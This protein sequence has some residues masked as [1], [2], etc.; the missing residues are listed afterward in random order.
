MSSVLKRGWVAT[1]L[2]GLVAG[3]TAAAPATAASPGIQAMPSPLRFVSHLDLECFKTNPYQ[4]PQT[5]IFTRHLNPVLAHLPNETHVLGPREQLCVPVAKNN[6]LPPAGVLEFVRFV[7]LSCY[8]IQGASVNTQLNLRHLNP[9]LQNLPPRNVYLTVPVQLCVPVIKNG[10]YPPPEIRQLAMYIDLKCY[11][12]QPNA[13]LNIGLGLRH[14]NP[15]LA[16]LPAHEARVTYN[17]Q[18]CV[19]VQKNNQPIPPEVLNIVRWIDLEKFDIITP[20]LQAPFNLTI[21]HLNP[22]LAH[23]PTEQVQIQQA[24]QLMLPVAK[25]NVIPPA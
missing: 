17:R 6:V 18:L 5:A 14:L 20:A 11:I 22:A 19:P 25:N 15:V 3:L 23:L 9:Q 24:T 1:V 16:N 10:L 13:P 12:E 2:M 7:D 8:K 21:N 4:P